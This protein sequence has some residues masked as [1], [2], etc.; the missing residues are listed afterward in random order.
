MYNE[1]NDQDW[2]LI[3]SVFRVEWGSSD[4]DHYSARTQVISDT[5]KAN[6]FGKQSQVGGRY[7]Y[8]FKEAGS[9][10]IS[11][12]M[13]QKRLSHQKPHHIRQCV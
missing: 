8:T 13:L 1:P 3:I 7:V 12:V 5:S 9:D 6:S 11:P 2:I 4:T 10:N